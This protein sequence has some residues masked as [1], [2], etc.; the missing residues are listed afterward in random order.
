MKTEKQILKKA[1]GKGGPGVDVIAKGIGQDIGG[2]LAPSIPGGA[3][4]MGRM[5]K[6]ITQKG[7]TPAV[8]RLPTQVPKAQMAPT[9]RGQVAPIPMPKGQIAPKQGQIAPKQGLPD[10]GVKKYTPQNL[11]PLEAIPSPAVDII[12]RQLGGPSPFKAKPTA[13]AKD[14]VQKLKENRKYGLNKPVRTNI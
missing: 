2:T 13:T 1:C 11:K 10:A 3:G 12:G 9:P 4:A 6:P 8:P 14:I 7:S 5:A